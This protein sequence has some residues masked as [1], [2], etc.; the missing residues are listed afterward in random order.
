MELP[1]S[2]R[3]RVDDRDGPGITKTS[4]PSSR[5]CAIAYCCVR[6]V[7]RYDFHAVCF[8][9]ARSVIFYY[10]HA[11][12]QCA[13]TASTEVA[14]SWLDSWRSG[15]SSHTRSTVERQG[16]DSGHGKSSRASYGGYEW[17]RGG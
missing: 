4:P 3:G 9:C 16:H 12:S 17:Q 7:T 8:Q 15:A 5:N 11:V 2:A 1:N 14:R 13:R 10:A 6:A